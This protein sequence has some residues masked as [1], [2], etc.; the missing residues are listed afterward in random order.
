MDVETALEQ[1]RLMVGEWASEMTTPE[2]N[3][4]DVYLN[5]PED[6]VPATVGL[7]V[8]RLGYLTAITGIDLGPEAGELEALY[9]FC[10][11]PA[12]IA[13]RVR[14]PRET[15]SI[16]T[17]SDFVPSAEVFER[18]LSEMFGITIIG[19]RNTDRLYLPDDWPEGVYPLRK[20]FDPQELPPQA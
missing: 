5:K 10:T 1:A 8:L 11:G 9:H 3:R 2:P 12:V 14:M 19:A 7:R 18:E 16:P 4:L 20:D 6:L 15:P 13:L 17:L